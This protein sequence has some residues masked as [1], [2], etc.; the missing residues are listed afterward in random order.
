MLAKVSL[1]E[2]CLPSLRG[3]LACTFPSDWE[4]GGRG[5]TALQ[6]FVPSEYFLDICCLIDLP[7]T[8]NIFDKREAAEKLRKI[9]HPL[10][11]SACSRSRG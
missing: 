11:T 7:V 6:G 10:P 2:S 9:G 4:D 5:R 3:R 1:D 8:V